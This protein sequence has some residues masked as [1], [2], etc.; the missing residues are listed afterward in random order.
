MFSQGFNPHP[1]MTVA[2][3]LSVGVT[4]DGEYM[5]VG[6]DGDYSE[7]DIKNTIN[8]ALPPGYIIQAVRKVEGK[9]IDLTKLDRAMYT[10]EAETEGEPDV[11]AFLKNSELTVPKKTKS[12]VKDSDIRPYIY[13]LTANKVS[14]NVTVFTMCVAMG[15]VYNLKP[16]T[17][18]DAI[19]KYAESFS[20]GFFKVH[21]NSMLM[22]DVDFL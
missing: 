12:G 14:D 10:V 5:K 21:R 13:A 3:P 8:A 11:D 4:A 6:F 2:Q 15:S 19:N 1:I 7:E 17:V 22:G 16:D 9:E 18:I 20:V